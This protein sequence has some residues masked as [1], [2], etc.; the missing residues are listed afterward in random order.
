M[1]SLI[2]KAIFSSVLKPLFEFMSQPIKLPVLLVALP[3]LAVA[4]LWWR[5]SSVTDKLDECRVI[6]AA[7]E[8]ANKQF[9]LQVARTNAS[10]ASARNEADA[11]EERARAAESAARAANSRGDT[12]VTRTIEAVRPAAELEEIEQCRASRQLLLDYYSLP[13]ELR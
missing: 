3:L 10:I 11:A 12:V 4:F 6:S 1:F 13:A 7:F 8:E 2:G 9:A 5:L